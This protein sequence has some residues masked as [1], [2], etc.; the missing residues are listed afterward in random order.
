MNAVLAGI[1]SVTAGLC[2]VYMGGRPGLLR[3]DKV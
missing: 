3:G 1:C 2:F